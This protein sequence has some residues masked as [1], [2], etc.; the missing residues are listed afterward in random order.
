[1]ALQVFLLGVICQE[2][3]LLDRLQKSVSEILPPPSFYGA[4][5][6]ASRETLRVYLL[7]TI[8]KTILDGPIAQKA[9]L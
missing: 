7:L 6:T 1:M 8:V 5:A 3:P 4:Q 9:L 2:V